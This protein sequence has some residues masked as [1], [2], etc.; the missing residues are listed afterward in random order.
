MSAN[1]RHSPQNSAIDLFVKFCKLQRI[2]QLLL[3]QSLECPKSYCELLHEVE[4]KIPKEH[5]KLH[6]AHDSSQKQVF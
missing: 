1:F 6:I 2:Q 5:T 4:V 3:H